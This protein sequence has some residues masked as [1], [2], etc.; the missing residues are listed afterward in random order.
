MLRKPRKN[1]EKLSLLQK[2]GLYFYSN[3]EVT[4]VYWLAVI[5]FGIICYTTLLPRQG[6]PNVD[7]PVSVVTGS[8][9]VND[10]TIVDAKL[11]KPAGAITKNITGVKEVNT[12]ASNNFFV[13]TVE[14]DGSLTSAE[15]NQKVKNALSDSPEVPKEATL[16]FRSIDA[17]R[18]DEQSDLLL[19]VYA[20]DGVTEVQLAEQAKKVASKL[21][22]SSA[23]KSAS[24]IN[25]FETG[26]NP[27]T[28][29]NVTLQTSFDITGKKDGIGQIHLTSSAIVGVRA[30]EGADAF[31][32]YD[33]VNEVL[34]SLRNNPDFANVD[35]LV[36]ADYA[37]GIKSQIS[38][39]QQSLFEGLIVV[40]LVS[41][42]LISWRAGL[43]TAL[44]MVTVLL[45]TIGVLYAT[46]T[47]LNTITL[48]ALILSLGLIVDDTTIMVEAIDA[49]KS[50]K[51]AKA[52]IVATAIKKVARASFAG[53]ITTMLGFAPM[54]FIGGIL[55][56]FI[57]ILPVTIIIALAMSLLVSLSLVPFFARFL[58]TGKEEKPTFIGRI[59][60]R[61]SGFF[62]GLVLRT[63]GSNKRKLVTSAVALGISGVFIVV[64]FFFFGKL[65]FDIFPSTKDTDALSVS[66]TTPPN[67]AIEDAIKIVN[68]VTKTTSDTVGSNFKRLSLQGT[69]SADGGTVIVD[70]ISYKE[71]EKTAPQLVEE[72]EKALQDT[73]GAI[74]RVSQI[75]VGPPKDAFPFTVRIE[76]DETEKT[77]KLAEDMRVFLTGR[78][79]ERVNGTTS[80]ITTAEVRND[81]VRRVNGKQYIAVR[82]S[83]AND[84]VSALVTA[85]QTAVEKEFSEQKLS[86][87][88][89]AKEALVFD[90]GNESDNQDSFR[91]MLVAFPVLLLAM[92]VL[93]A[94]QFRSLLQPLL[95]FAAI[96]YSFFGVAVGLYVTD[97]PLSFFVMIGFFALI[98]IAV[99]NTILLTDY[100]NQARSEG[101]GPTDAIA[102][103]IRAR[104]RPLITTSLT[105]VVALVPLALSDP[106][107]ESLA[108]TLIF[109]L[110]SSTF[111][112]VVSFPY[113]YLIAEWMRN[114]TRRSNKRP[115]RI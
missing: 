25:Q 34:T 82:A 46:G 96:P 6:F 5:V 99:N 112:V 10:K 61:I 67:T 90:F 68:D 49:A 95:I 80:T 115:S 56:D 3:K 105:S 35:F 69:G 37:E 36:V 65:K 60:Q 85:A 94:V 100:A 86:S 87:Y 83:F 16:E 64:S 54:L 84:D 17:S 78:T 76:G 73:K 33:G 89:I 40:I 31:A 22:V 103:A 23:V 81:A 20:K 91:T 39:L 28:G 97:N 45:A 7:V 13:M 106:F 88:G 74:I 114:K 2:F 93:L 14:Y 108:Y 12:E 55:G 57:R 51:L 42:L 92:F 26:Q 19:A 104:F 52:Q 79:I 38:G 21:A 47:S 1:T 71:R 29:E 50:K 62:A 48:F 113:M 75:D 59:E 4:L 109:G 58:L 11:A 15:G 107:W 41:F 70:L 8:Y 53:T 32:I 72:V 77:Q 111:L 98:G 30:E 66:V 110:L 24:Y 9:F 43:A 44:S 27:E 101:A 18:F 102:Q 63:K